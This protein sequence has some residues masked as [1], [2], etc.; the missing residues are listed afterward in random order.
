MKW[1]CRIRVQEK[2]KVSKRL[3]VFLALGSLFLPMYG[4]LGALGYQRSG[5][6][7]RLATSQQ[8]VCPGC[9][10]SGRGSSYLARSG[11]DPNTPGFRDGQCPR[12]N[13]SGYLVW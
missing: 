9:G 3:I 12:C 2:V 4:C 7:Q 13:G 10:G 5:S 8:R 6:S 1:N 11:F